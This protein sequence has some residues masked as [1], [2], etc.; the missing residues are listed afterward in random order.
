MPN[1]DTVERLKQE[2][3]DKTKNPGKTSSST[4][5]KQAS[6]EQIPVKRLSR[7][8]HTKQGLCHYTP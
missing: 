4:E 7:L 2:I 5:R 3:K 8:V 1:A 6:L